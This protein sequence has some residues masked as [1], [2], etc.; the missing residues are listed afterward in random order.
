LIESA[1]G[2][3]GEGRSAVAGDIACGIIAVGFGSRTLDVKQAVA[4]GS[5]G[6]QVGDAILVQADAV[7]TGIGCECYQQ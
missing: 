6:G 4:A 7:E 2:I 1:C 3:P 5:D